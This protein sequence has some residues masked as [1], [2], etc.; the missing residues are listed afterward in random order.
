[1]TASVVFFCIG[2]KFSLWFFAFSL[3]KFLKVNKQVK[4]EIIEKKLGRVRAIGDVKGF[5]L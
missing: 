3:I 5:P 1:M 4:C 2:K